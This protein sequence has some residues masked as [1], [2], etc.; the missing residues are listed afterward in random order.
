MYCKYCGKEIPNGSIFCPNCGA[1]QKDNVFNIKSFFR[2]LYANHKKLSYSYIAWCLFHIGLLLFSSPKVHG[3]DMSDGFYPFDESLSDIIQGNSYTCSLLENVD[4]YDFSEFF[5]YTIILPVII[6]G[7]AKICFRYFSRVNIQCIRNYV[8]R[9]KV[10]ATVYLAWVTFHGIIYVL[11]LM[12]NH[13]FYP[14]SNFYP[15][16]TTHYKTKIYLDCI[17]TYDYT[18]FLI[19]VLLLPTVCFAI[20]KLL[21]VIF[22]HIDKK[23]CNNERKLNDA[24]KPKCIAIIKIKDD[25]LRII[26]TVMRYDKSYVESDV[27]M[28]PLFNRF[29][30]SMMDKIILVVL[31][32]VVT[33]VMRPFAGAGRLGTYIGILTSTPVNYEY[34][35]RYKIEEYNSNE[36][37]KGNSYF[38]QDQARLEEEPPHMGSTKELDLY[39]TFSFILLNL[40]YYTLFELLLG[41]SLGKMCLGGILVNVNN[42]RIKYG[43]VLIRTLCAGI[44]MSIFVF[45]HFY[46]YLNYLIA[47][48]LYFLLMD[49]PVFVTKKSLLDLCTETRFIK[50]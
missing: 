18:E 44:F 15:F 14:K 26:N 50:R 5:F 6:A 2:E 31:F 7:F 39:M 43:R 34:I 13:P 19:Y 12:V 35:D 21:L 25:T 27:E 46:I 42:E 37:E 8:K 3:Y 16:V 33:I 36:Y 10:I 28:M 45:L 40:L 49:I 29:I 23:I 24:L 1:K 48:V 41:A 32:V 38:F 17:G 20:G 30:G 9:H 47:I 4:V 11:S 22:L